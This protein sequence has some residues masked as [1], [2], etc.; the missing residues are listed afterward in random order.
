MRENRFL[1]S[2]DQNQ[3]RY[4]KRPSLTDSSGSRSSIFHEPGESQ[5]SGDIRLG[6]IA[7]TEMVFG[8]FKKELVQHLLL[9]GRSGS[10]KTNV[11]RILQIELHRI[12]IPFMTFDIAKY[13]SRFLKHYMQ[14]LIILRWNKEFVFNPLM[15]PP[16]VSLKEWLLVFTEISTDLFGLRTASKMFLLEFIMNRLFQHYE[17]GKIETCPTMHDLK[18]ELGKRLGEKIP[19]NERGYINSINSK[20]QSICV[21]L[22]SMLNVHVG[23]P[24]DK[25]LEYPVCIELVGIKS[26]EIQVWIISLVLAWIAA[27]REARQMSFGS[28]KHVLIFDEAAKLVGRGEK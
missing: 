28:L 18:F 15:H 19:V 20:I 5:V 1:T 26:T 17:S 7:D 14:D 23:I 9:I 10:G 16:C 11:I 4:F 21:T 2:T 24:I 22:D 8:I 6:Y 12:G 25:L 13:G 27:Y 3:Y